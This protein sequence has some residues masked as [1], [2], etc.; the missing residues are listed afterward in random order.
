M[1][2]KR[3]HIENFRKLKNV[4]V[5]FDEATFLIGAN[6]S[7]KSSTLDA[8]EYLLSDKRQTFF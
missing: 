1:K 4:D 8:I 2:L 6:N 7:G 3:L 5:I